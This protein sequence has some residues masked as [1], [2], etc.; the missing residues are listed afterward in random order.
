MKGYFEGFSCHLDADRNSAWSWWE[1]L[2]KFWAETLR[3]DKPD[4]QSPNRVVLETSAFSL[5]SFTEK[6]HGAPLLI[7]GPQAGHHTC[8]ADYAIPGQSLVE[9]CKKATDRP[10][11]A[12]EWK[13]ADLCRTGETIDDLVKQT[14]CCVNFLGNKVHIVGLCQAGW[15][16]SI[17]AALYPETVL[18]LILGGA[19]IDFTAG[20]G[21]IQDMVQNLPMAFYG[22]LVMM[23]FG[24]MY[25]RFIVT[26]FKNMNPYDRYIKDHLN[27]FNN[28]H[29]EQVVQRTRRFR[30]WYEHTQSISGGW[31]LQAVYELFKRNRLVRGRLRVLGRHVLLQ[32][33][34]CPVVLIAGEKDDITL[35][36]QLFNMANH[37][38]GKVVK[39]VIPG[40]GHIGLFMKKQALE[41]YWSPALDIVLG[42]E[43]GDTRVMDEVA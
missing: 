1:N 28:I 6:R 7:L 31:Y 21:K 19:P 36:P 29:D 14:A 27:L 4:W 22:S 2:G 40:C 43:K 8:I 37:V 18:S 41:E 34:T 33:I 12:I 13:G 25:G 26:G 15:L 5:R 10:V 32:N 11:Y 16:S 3:H 42:E 17:Y 30:R 9:L 39:M 35:E 38:S 23:G 24:V 20:G